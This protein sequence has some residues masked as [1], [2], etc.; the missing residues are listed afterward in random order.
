MSELRKILDRTHCDGCDG[1]CA[2]LDEDQPTLTPAEAERQVL[3]LIKEMI[4]SPVRYGH[5][6]DELEHAYRIGQIELIE[7]QLERAGL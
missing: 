4:G 6:E 5:P 7:Q 3:K 2:T 1:Y